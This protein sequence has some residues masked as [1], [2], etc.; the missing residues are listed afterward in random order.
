MKSF[1]IVANGT[2]MG[3]YKAAD[4]S[5]AIMAYVKDAGYKTVSAAADACGQTEADF[6]ADIEAIEL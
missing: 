3:T 2:E 1:K 5:A 4:A 6:L